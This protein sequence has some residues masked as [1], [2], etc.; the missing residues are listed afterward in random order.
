MIRN[1]IALALMGWMALPSLGAAQDKSFTVEYEDAQ[2]IDPAQNPVS[3]KIKG[4]AGNWADGVWMARAKED[5]F[6]NLYYTVSTINRDGY[7]GE[8]MF[9]LLNANSYFADDSLRAQVE[10][11]EL[12]R[13][14]KIEFGAYNTVYNGAA[15]YRYIL[16]TSKNAQEETSSCVH[17]QANWRRFISAG[18]LCTDATQMR[19]TENTARTFIKAIGYQ[20]ELSPVEGI[21]PLAGDNRG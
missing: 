8:L 3:L 13:G 16:F 20:Q 6:R 9:S 12:F 19:L 21:L 11:H 5:Q 18:T 7:A 4:W 14:T 15:E 2:Q 10:R 1:L 17:F